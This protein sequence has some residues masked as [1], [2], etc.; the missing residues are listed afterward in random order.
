MCMFARG[1]ILVIKVNENSCK[2]LREGGRVIPRACVRKRHLGR[3]CVSMCERP[4]MDIHRV[5]VCVREKVRVCVT[6]GLWR[7]KLHVKD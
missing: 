6:R 1:T 3:E 2:W 4:P 5:R 7:V